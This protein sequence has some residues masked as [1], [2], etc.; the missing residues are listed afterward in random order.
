M[1]K[2]GQLDCCKNYS[3]HTSYDAIIL[4]FIYQKKSWD[5][6]LLATI[7]LE[8]PVRATNGLAHAFV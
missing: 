6:P 4:I 1:S 5:W 7:G 2:V 3:E 8:D